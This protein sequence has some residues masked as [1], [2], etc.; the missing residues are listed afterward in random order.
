MRRHDHARF[1]PSRRRAATACVLTAHV[2]KEHAA[3]LEKADLGHP[4][5]P[6]EQLRVDLDRTHSRFD[7]K[8]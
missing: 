8:L 2:Y 4:E 7:D 3:A 5:D 1:E 6:V